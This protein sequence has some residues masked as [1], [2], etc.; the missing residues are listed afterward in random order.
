MLPS[1]PGFSLHKEGSLC[2]IL[3]YNLYMGTNVMV[4]DDLIPSLLEAVMKR[5][6]TDFPS[7]P[8]WG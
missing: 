3:A 4:S 8:N 5:I 1:L 2:E 6:E 7:W